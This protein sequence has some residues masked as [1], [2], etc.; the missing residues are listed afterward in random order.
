MTLEA[1]TLVDLRMKVK[2][3]AKELER[4]AQADGP[5]PYADR[6]NPREAILDGRFNLEHLVLAIAGIH[7]DDASLDTSRETAP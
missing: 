7:P 4:Q 3:A 5:S 1:A 2:R 6:D